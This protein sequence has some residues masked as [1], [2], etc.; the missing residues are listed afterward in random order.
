MKR[1]ISF[2][3]F[4]LI[5]VL[6]HPVYVEKHLFFPQDLPGKLDRIENKDKSITNHAASVGAYLT[7]GPYVKLPAGIYKT[8]IFYHLGEGSEGFA[9]ISVDSGKTILAKQNLSSSVDKIKKSFWLKS[10]KDIEIRIFVGKGQL[11]LYKIKIYGLSL[12]AFILTALIVYMVIFGRR[13]LAAAYKKI[14]YFRL[15]VCMTVF[16]LALPLGYLFGAHENTIL[17]GRDPLTDLPDMHKQSF[18]DKSFQKQFEN[19]W[20][21]HF[22]FRRL[23]LKTKNQI[24]D[25]VNFNR[26]HSGYNK[27]VVQGADYY[28]FERGYFASFRLSC[29]P[30]PEEGFKKFENLNRAL[31]EN[32]IDLYVV[33]APNKAVTYQDHIPLHYKFFLG[34]DCG[35][36]AKITENLRKRGIKVF[37]GQSLMADLR[38]GEYQ[39]FSKTGTHWN[40]FGAGNVFAAAFK[41]FGLSN[42]KVTEIQTSKKPYITERDIADLLNRLD[43]YETGEEYPRPLFEISKALSGKTGI[44][45]NSFSNEFKQSI[46]NA[47][48]VSSKNLVYEGNPPLTPEKTRQLLQTN[49]IFMV[50]T[51]LPFM[52]INDQMFK[53][54][55]MLLTYADTNTRHIVFSDPKQPVENKGLSHVEK[56]GR[57]SAGKEVVLTLAPDKKADN[58]VITFDIQPYVNEKHKKQTVTVWADDEKLAEWHFDYAKK[59]PET[60]LNYPRKYLSPAGEIRLRFEISDPKSPYEL[61]LSSDKRKLGIGFKKMDIKAIK[62]AS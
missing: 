20:T 1:F 38:R 15:F 44:I 26:I 62:K 5:I 61:G 50:Y 30:L 4:L 27:N 29:R 33:L 10:R 11:T 37:N 47:G 57:W 56:W 60:A 55:D 25:W 52:N 51:D 39:P 43:F 34:K 7:Y 28:L 35:Y 23:A 46:L 45:G 13:R 59:Q 17:F 31:K 9:D 48:V 18:A 2:V 40:L 19:W 22:L 8:S 53:K 58:Y 21:S 49:R 54:I 3:L 14:G 32:D 36:Y 42:V 6:L 24:Y 41:E 12:P 16:L